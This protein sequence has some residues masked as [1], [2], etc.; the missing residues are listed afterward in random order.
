MGESG[1]KALRPVF[2]VD[3]FVLRKSQ[4][5]RHGLGSLPKGTYT[6]H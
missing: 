4:T 3:A 2:R 6:I 1:R 5:L